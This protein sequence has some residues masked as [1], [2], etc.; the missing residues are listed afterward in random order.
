[1]SSEFVVAFKVV[2]F[3]QWLGAIF[4]VARSIV[5]VLSESDGM[6]FLGALTGSIPVALLAILLARLRLRPTRHVSSLSGG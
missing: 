5:A 1:M 4:L 6:S 2:A 3:L